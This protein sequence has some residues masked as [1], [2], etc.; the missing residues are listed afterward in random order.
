M[1]HQTELELGLDYYQILGV[2]VTASAAEIRYAYLE[3]MRQCHPDRVH[4]PEKRRIA[5]ERA[6]LLNVAY[7]V[8]GDPEKRRR[9]D[10]ILQQRALADLLF[11]R[12]TTPRPATFQ[13]PG[14]PR[15]RRVATNDVTAVVQ[16]LAVTAIFVAVFVL[17][18]VVS[19]LL[20]TLLGA[21]S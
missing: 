1:S 12:Y 18:L 5:E 3:L 4:D 6:K 11:Q 2:P 21:V 7:G 13:A 8:L 19:S 17:L 14:V 9:Y 10:E 20:S 16:L 15:K